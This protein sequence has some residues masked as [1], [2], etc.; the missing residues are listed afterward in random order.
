MFGLGRSANEK[1]VINL[2]ALQL[3]AIG[4]P[5]REAV[6]SATKLVDDVLTEIRPRGI[7]PFKS[8]QGNEYVAREQ[9]IAPRLAAGL[10]TEN[11]RSHWNRPLLVVLCEFKM[12][13]IVNFTVIRMADLQGKD[14]IKAGDQYKRAFPRYGDS[15]QWNPT[16]KLNVGLRECDA[17]IYPEFAGRVDAWQRRTGDTEVARLIKEHGTLNAAI[18]QQIASGSL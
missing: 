2:F 8:T 13:E 12:H 17:D 5:S 14:L 6:G 4:L 9:F 16:E 15:A 10:T 11:I 18:R 7:N 1:A 3:E